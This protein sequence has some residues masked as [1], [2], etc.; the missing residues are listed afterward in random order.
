[1]QLTIVHAEQ[2]I[3]YW[4]WY[5][6]KKRF[7]HNYFLLQTNPTLHTLLILKIPVSEK[8]DFWTDPPSAELHK[9]C[10]TI[11]SPR[12]SK[13]TLGSSLSCT[14]GVL[15]GRSSECPGRNTF[16]PSMFQTMILYRQKETVYRPGS[17][18]ENACECTYWVKQ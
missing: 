5:S 14:H 17:P 13:S 11:Q 2:F 9:K 15:L 4:N 18:G 10:P 7:K 12:R 8:L 16:Q 1:M 3:R 6:V